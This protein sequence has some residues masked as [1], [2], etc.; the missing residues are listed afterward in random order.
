[1]FL[2][3]LDYNTLFLFLLIIL[4]I[5]RRLKMNKFTGKHIFLIIPSLEQ[6]GA[7]RVSG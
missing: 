2:T 1:M 3:I 4:Q 7:E 5:K 6:G